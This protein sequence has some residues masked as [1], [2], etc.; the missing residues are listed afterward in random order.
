M[1]CS[2]NAIII[3]III[4]VIVINGCVNSLIMV[5]FALEQAVEVQRRKKCGR[6]ASRYGR[7]TPGEETRYALFRRLGGLQG[8]SGRV[9]KTHQD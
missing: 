3:V 8:R 2:F 6:C 5:K 7:L 9:R 4:I 1:V